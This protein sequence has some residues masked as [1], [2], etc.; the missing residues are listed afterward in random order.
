M[1]AA[2]ALP[3]VNPP[4]SLR[5]SW[6]RH[7]ELLWLPAFVLAGSVAQFLTAHYLGGADLTPQNLARLFA[8]PPL[9]TFS[10]LRIAGQSRQLIPLLV[11]TRTVLVTVFVALLTG[12]RFRLVNLMKV[13]G[14]NVLSLATL[15]LSILLG[16]AYLAHQSSP[17]QL[18]LL[19]SQ[20]LLMILTTR[21]LAPMIC[22]AAAGL[23]VRPL[24]A[25]G[26]MW[27]YAFVSVWLWMFTWE[28]ASIYALSFVIVIAQSVLL[29]AI[30]LRSSQVTSP[31]TST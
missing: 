24:L 16:L 20:P 2:D 5:A 28:K 21:V 4:G 7:V 23:S 15:G 12:R 29:G 22:R 1:R 11:A 3:Q 27:L 9:D 6:R 19:I 18:A 17:G 10:D 30:A 8:P 13:A 31:P 26:R 25:D 14:L